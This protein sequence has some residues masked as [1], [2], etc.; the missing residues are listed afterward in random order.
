[1]LQNFISSKTRIKILRLFLQ[2][3]KRHY[4]LREIS[5]L[6]GES[7]TP[8]RRE[9]INLRKIG[10]LKEAKVANLVYYDVNKKFLLYDELTNIVKKTEPVEEEKLTPP[11]LQQPEQVIIRES[12]FE[13]DSGNTNDV[14]IV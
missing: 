10:L 9:L 4:Y 7:L 13:T 14:P 11:Q 3:P 2:H 6:L 5:K 1:M 8:V 12:N